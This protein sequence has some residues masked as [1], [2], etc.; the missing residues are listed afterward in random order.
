MCGICGIYGGNDK[1]LIL[2][3]VRVLKHRSPDGNGYYADSDCA[4]GHARLSINDLTKNGAQ[5]MCNETEDLW[6]SINGE[7]YNFKEL[8]R[9]LE[10]KGHQFKS[11]SDS[12]V[13]LHSYE[14]YGVSFL[15]SLHGMY[16]L[17]L[18]DQSNKRL[19][20][21]RDP[22]GKKPLYYAATENGELIFASK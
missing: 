9:L 3:M 17:A 14:E 13:A 4:M 21:A 12:E 2:K 20:L 18:Y 7:I 15:H 1:D 16:A 8:R 5:P 6:L 10:K 11:N 19:I 22:I